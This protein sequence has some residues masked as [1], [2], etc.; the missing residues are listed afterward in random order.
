MKT[1]QGTT[2]QLKS[3]MEA[4]NYDPSKVGSAKMLQLLQTP[5]QKAATADVVAYVSKTCGIDLTKLS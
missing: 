5:E 1:L 4:N 2:L 3:L